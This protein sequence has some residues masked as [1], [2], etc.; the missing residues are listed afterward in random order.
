MDACNL[1]VY[2]A[3]GPYNRA[4]L[5]DGKPALLDRLDSRLRSIPFSTRRATFAEVKRVHDLLSSISV[6]GKQIIVNT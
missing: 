3:A 5:F 4:V 6:Y 2:R 1:I